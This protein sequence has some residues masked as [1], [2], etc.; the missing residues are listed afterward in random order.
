MDVTFEEEAWWQ[1]S[2]GGVLFWAEAQGHAIRCFVSREVVQAL[3]GG[4]TSEDNTL[5][6]FGEH[7]LVFEAEAA[8]MIKTNRLVRVEGQTFREA[9]ILAVPVA[10]RPCS[11]RYGGELAWESDST[12]FGRRL[13]VDAGLGRTG[14]QDRHLRY[15]RSGRFR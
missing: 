5:A 9:Q 13:L 11:S 12:L 14:K 1:G 15:R 8:A 7:R 4:D 10:R 2:R 6:F 3:Y